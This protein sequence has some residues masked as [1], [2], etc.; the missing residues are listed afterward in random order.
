[1]NIAGGTDIAFY[2]DG[3]LSASP[4]D[5]GQGGRRV[6]DPSSAG[7]APPATQILRYRLTALSPRGRGWSP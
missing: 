7:S 5:D 6:A 2:V 3:N 1:M 4:F